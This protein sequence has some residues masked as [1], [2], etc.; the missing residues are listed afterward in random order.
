MIAKNVSAYELFTVDRSEEYRYVE[1]SGGI[2]VVGYSG[3]R[4]YIEIPETIEGKKLLL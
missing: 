1:V 4:E 3:L 2:K